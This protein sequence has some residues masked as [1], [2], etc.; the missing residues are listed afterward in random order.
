MASMAA[1]STIIEARTPAFAE[2]IADVA[3]EDADI[4]ACVP[5]GETRNV[6]EQRP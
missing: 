4:G 6:F 3:E 5:P 1:A 2:T